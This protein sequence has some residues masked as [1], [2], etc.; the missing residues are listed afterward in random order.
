LLKLCWEC[1]NS[2]KTHLQCHFLPSQYLGVR[3]SGWMPWCITVKHILP[4]RTLSDFD[5]NESF[6]IKI[7]REFSFS[8]LSG[9][10]GY[11]KSKLGGI[12]TTIS[13]LEAVCV[14]MNDAL[15]LVKST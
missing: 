12:S 4:L 7:V 15:V 5:S 10:L 8:N 1:R 9:N 14:E 6:S 3:A 2:S 13:R 11:I